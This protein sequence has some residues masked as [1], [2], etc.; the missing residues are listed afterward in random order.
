MFP[1]ERSMEYECPI[2]VNELESWAKTHSPGTLPLVSPS[3][4]VAPLSLLL[5]A[6][7]C[8]S[9]R[10]CPDVFLSFSVSSSSHAI[11]HPV[12]LTLAPSALRR[13]HVI[14]LHS[15][16]GRERLPSPSPGLQQC[17]SAATPTLPSADSRDQSFYKCLSE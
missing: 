4:G 17:I 12:L 16:V 2:D 8:S 15:N 3:L 10:L 5:V 7:V 11:L 13:F 1:Q 14:L 6:L 9:T